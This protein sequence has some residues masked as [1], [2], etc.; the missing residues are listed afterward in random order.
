MSRIRTIK[1]E[2]LEDEKTAQLDHLSW[3]VFVSL[4]ILADDYGNGRADHRWLAGQI[5]WA[6]D[7]DANDIRE[8]LARLSRDSREGARDSLVV[9]YRVSG[10]AYYAVR[11]WARHQK[12][13]KPGKP[14]VPGPEMA[15]PKEPKHAIST[16][17]EG[18][19]RESR[20]SLANIRETLAPDPD[21]D[22]DPDQEQEQERAPAAAA[23]D[24]AAPGESG[25]DSQVSA[26]VEAAPD[27]WLAP[28]P[29]EQDTL[30]RLGPLDA[31]V[32]REACEYASRRAKGS[33]WAYAATRAADR[34]SKPRSPGKRNTG[35]PAARDP[36]RERMTELA[37]RYALG[38][39]GK[40]LD[41]LVSLD[42]TEPI[43]APLAAYAAERGELAT[44][45]GFVE[46]ERQR[47]AKLAS[48]G[49]AL[50]AARGLMTPSR[51][52]TG[53]ECF[54]G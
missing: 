4:I 25:P 20:E 23:A 24:S 26:L 27:D 36:R 21:P 18:S 51:N 7:D 17:C 2:I 43:D 45:A 1:P 29:E 38:A 10:Q 16:T 8:A 5:T 14:R 41:A 15:D 32:W 44:W 30:A 11:Q 37:E 13:D 50:L 40:W 12:V 33:R 22:Q 42:E 53:E 34:S 39:P 31:A 52:G 6:T 9:L 47:R 19:S 28:T 54:D 49:M 46:R 35:P 48:E 3:R